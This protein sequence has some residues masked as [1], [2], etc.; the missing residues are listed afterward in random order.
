[1]LRKGPVPL[2]V[3]GVVEYLVGVLFLAAPYLFDFDATRATTLSVAVGVVVLVVAAV[4]VGPTGLIDEL[5]L[6][7]HVALD[8]VLAVFWVAIPFV[9]GISDDGRATAFFLVVGVS[10]LLLTI[11]TSFVRSEPEATL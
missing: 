1:M 11:A 4:T 7:A 10:H 8:Y 3:H 2:A 6:P 9:F 5:P